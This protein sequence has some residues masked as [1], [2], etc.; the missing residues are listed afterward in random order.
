MIKTNFQHDTYINDPKASLP[1][2]SG[3]STQKTTTTTTE[4]KY[5][6]VGSLSSG[7]HRE[8]F[9]WGNRAAVGEEQAKGDDERDDDSDAEKRVSVELRVQPAAPCF[10]TAS[11]MN[12]A[13]LDWG[14]RVVSP[15]N[16][17]EEGF[18]FPPS[19]IIGS[20]QS[21]QDP[22]DRRDDG[23]GEDAGELGWW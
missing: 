11:Y 1:G 20:F 2:E 13:K 12:I 14:T 6:R 15:E 17:V 16:S 18:N 22:Y 8:T 3:E 10:D 23:E 5:R 21:D 7:N 4:K 9:A 19:A